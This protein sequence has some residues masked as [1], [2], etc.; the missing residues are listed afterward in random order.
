M[1]VGTC[2]A[3]WCKVFSDTWQEVR[4]VERHGW[5][6][7]Y[8]KYCCG[9]WQAFIFIGEQVDYEADGLPYT[10]SV[11]SKCGTLIICWLNVGSPPSTPAQHHANIG[12]T[13]C[14]CPD[15]SY[16]DGWW[17]PIVCHVYNAVMI[18]WGKHQTCSLCRCNVGPAS[19]T[20]AQH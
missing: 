4:F 6:T 14:V 18:N 2:M 11:S 13:S 12:W 7:V 5:W 10:L 9:L 20:L 19:Q 1:L 8:V 15:V 3:M 16:F 17:N